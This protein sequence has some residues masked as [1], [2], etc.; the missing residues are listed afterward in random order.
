MVEQYNWSVINIASDKSCDVILWSSKQDSKD[1]RNPEVDKIVSTTISNI[2]NG[3]IVLFH[4]YVYYDTSNTVEALKVI[5][6][7]LID[8]G[9]K[10]VTVS[11]LIKLS[12]Y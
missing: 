9:Y 7:E 6:P 2:E 10:F 5:I 8:K 11:E 3:D 12:Q 4:D 1:W